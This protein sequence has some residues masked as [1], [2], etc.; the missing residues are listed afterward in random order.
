MPFES[1]DTSVQET[2]TKVG[3]VE[4][5]TFRRNRDLPGVKME[6]IVTVIE[7]GHKRSKRVPAAKVDAGWPGTS[8]TLRAHLFAAIDNAE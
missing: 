1:R 7:D 5:I 4:E 8:K 6:I 2:V 3:T